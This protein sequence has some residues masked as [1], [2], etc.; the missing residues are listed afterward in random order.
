MSGWAHA[1]TMHARRRNREWI[2]GR[3]VHPVFDHDEA[4][5]VTATAVTI[6]GDDIIGSLTTH[7]T[8]TG[9]VAVIHRLHL[10]NNDTSE[11]HAAVYLV[12]SAGSA[13]VASVIYFDRLFPGQSV[14]LEG[15]WFIEAGDTLQSI[16]TTAGAGEVA[17]RGEGLELDSV[18]PFVGL[19]VVDGVALTNS[20]S[21]IY[22]APSSDVADALVAAVTVCNSN[23][24]PHVVTI[25]IRP[26]GG[27][28]QAR[29]NVLRQSLLSGETVIVGGFTLK[30]G[31]TI[32]AMA[33]T[34]GVVSC[35]PTPVEFSSLLT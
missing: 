22:A 17:L 19:G 8:A 28:Q 21:S 25:E 18:V 23:V 29:Q 32:Y 2:L 24:V 26:N 9:A 27:S 35:R 14:T 15:P 1:D 16:S 7:F 20:L 6:Q 33:D 30:P 5:D 4:N 13:G 31:D 10:T 12:P 11:N 34:G 3:L